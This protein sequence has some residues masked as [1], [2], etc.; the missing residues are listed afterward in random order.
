[1]CDFY[2]NKIN[3]H[4]MSF[5]QHYSICIIYFIVFKLLQVIIF[6][7]FNVCTLMLVLRDVLNII[8]KLI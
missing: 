3:I 1:M 5:H 7:G 4:L 6:T 8:L 2:V